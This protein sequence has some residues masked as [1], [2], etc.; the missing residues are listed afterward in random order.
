MAT[1][2]AVREA[3]GSVSGVVLVARE[4]SLARSAQAH[5]DRALA[6]LAEAERRVQ[7]VTESAPDAVISFDD[8]GVVVGWNPAAE[9]L[10]GLDGGA[11]AG[12]SI[13][14]LL[15]AP[16]D[17]DP[18][19]AA[20]WLGLAGLTSR[21]DGNR[22]DGSRFP[23]EI[24]IGTY[25]DA[26][27]AWF[28]AFVR[29]ISE[30]IAAEARAADHEHRY[31]RLVEHLPGVVY[32]A[33]AGRWAPLLYASPHLEELL[34]FRPDEWIGVRGAWEERMHPADRERVLAQNDAEL[35]R[36]EAGGPATDRE[37]R[38]RRRDGSEIW[39]R[40]H[41]VLERD[42]DGTPHAWNG[43]LVDITERKR[44][45][46]ELLHLAFHDPLTGLANRALLNDR[47]AHA[48]ARRQREAGAIAILMVD[49]DDFKLINDAHGHDAGDRLLVAAAERLRQC[50]RADATIARLGGDEFAILLEGLPD[51]GAAL[52]VAQRVV[53]AFERPLRIEGA[54]LTTRVS[55]GVAIDVTGKRTATWL[56]RSADTAMYEAKRQGKG[57]W[58]AY[59]PAAHLASA[60]RLVLESELRRAVERRQFILVYQPIVDLR[61]GDIVGTEALIRWNHP[62][63]GLIA[64]TEF[65]SILESTGLIEPVGRWV[66][67]EACR[68][69]AAWEQQLPSLQWTAVNVSAAQLRSDAFLA[70]VKASLAEHGLSPERL[71]VEVTEGLA[72]DDSAATVE[73]LHRL[74][75]LG[76][77]IAV[78]DFGTGYSSL[79]YLRRLPIDRIKIDRSFVDGLGVDPE[80]LAVARAIVDL[81]RSLRLGIVAEGIEQKA[82]A[83]SLIALG[84]ELGQGFLFARPLRAPELA[85]VVAGRLAAAAMRPPSAV[86]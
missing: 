21:A 40:D 67:D 71:S 41:A 77:R 9:R 58:Q 64:P 59:D 81:G 52:V 74:R 28:T 13:S 35:S 57:R 5:V 17:D 48:I 61:S 65:I 45:E 34:G 68:Q 2:S 26:G 79:S 27:R 83:D 56:M 39:V 46:S 50:V 12:R 25:T 60:K 16:D 85:A 42:A 54:T 51:D 47:I 38:M 4:A 78:D 53:R 70:S 66:I 55:L 73:R 33:S 43:F 6:R 75:A 7:L 72:M 80:A 44:L 19:E 31:R 29:D 8:A 14:S 82:Q 49:L 69:A 11:A 20:A 62:N 76:L 24:T 36:P 23:V 32:R 37:Y 30:R 84:C 3:D 86:A 10:F 18:L 22:A 15:R 63:R 1:W